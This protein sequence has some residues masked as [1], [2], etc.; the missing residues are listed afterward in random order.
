MFQ[1]IN[2]YFKSTIEWFLLH[3]KEFDL[4]LLKSK[5]NISISNSSLDIFKFILSI[6][7][8]EVSN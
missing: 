7:S 1:I 4:F 5:L 2:L 8:Y 3:T 6:M